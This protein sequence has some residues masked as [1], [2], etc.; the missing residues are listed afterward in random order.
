M[1]N[2]PNN[3]HFLGK[4]TNVSDYLLCTDA[5]VLTSTFEG[6]PISLL[7][8]LSAGAV[9]VCTPVGGIINIVAKN[10][11]F[12]STDIS[13]EAFSNALRSYLNAD[14]ATINNL[15]QNGKDLYNKE[16]SMKT[17]AAKYDALYHSA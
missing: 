7:E 11:G 12:L 13:I 2:K 9:P 10:I 3:V 8:A 4:V 15:K 1:A 5:F 17:C 6:L 14:E 16:F